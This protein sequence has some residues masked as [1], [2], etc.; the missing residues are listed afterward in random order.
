MS[1]NP[2]Y[3]SCQITPIYSALCANATIFS[4]S[5]LQRIESGRRD[6]TYSVLARIAEYCGKE[7]HEIIEIENETTQ[8]DTSEREERLEKIITTQNEQITALLEEIKNLYSVVKNLISAGGDD[9]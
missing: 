2:C 9:L 1:S 8:L 6:L 5:T 3:T 7:I 4:L